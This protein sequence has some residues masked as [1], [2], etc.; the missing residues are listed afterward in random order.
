MTVTVV[1][2]YALAIAA[3]VLMLL[4]VVTLRR[5]VAASRRDGEP[6]PA[7]AILVFGGGVRPEGPS[8][9]VRTRVDHAARLYDAGLAPLVFCSGGCEGALSEA[10]VMRGL[11]IEH[12]V[13]ADAVIPDDHGLSTRLALESARRMGRGRWHRIIL[14]S[15]PHHLH[16]AELEACRQGLT[17]DTVAARR[18]GRSTWRH[19]VFDIRQHVREVLAVWGYALTALPGDRVNEWL[20]IR[21]ARQIGARLAY[22]FGGADAV[23]AASVAIG[24]AIK[25]RVADVLDTQSVHTPA[26]GLHWPAAGRVGHPFGMRHGR[27]HGGVDLRAA[28]G[29]PVRAA[30]DG[31]VLLADWIG[32]YG[33]V[34]VVHH[35]GG[36][37]TCYA[38]LGGFVVEERAPVVEGALLGFVGSTGRSSGPHL[39]FE[40]RVHGSP[41]DPLV[42][43]PDTVPY[44]PRRQGQHNAVWAESI[45]LRGH[46]PK[47]PRRVLND[48]EFQALARRLEAN[49][50]RY[51]YLFA[52]PYDGHGGVPAYAMS[53][54][55]RASVRRLRQLVPDVVLLPW[56]GGL[57]H[58]TV[59]LEDPQWVARAIEET[60]R[61]V[62]TLDVPGVHVDFE[63]IVPE[64]TY[65]RRERN[66]PATNEGL[67][68]YGARHVAFTRALRERLPQAFLSVVIPSTS[69]HVRPWKQKH[70][71]EEAAT[72]ATLVDQ[73]ALMHYD[74]SIADRAVFAASLDEQ[75]RHVADWRARSAS[76]RT[77]FLLAVGT[78]VNARPLRHHR[79]LDV[80][81]LEHYLPAI[82]AAIARTQRDVRLV[83]GL[84]VYCDWT[85]KDVD[86]RRFRRL[87]TAGAH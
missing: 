28:Q 61:L 23:A 9:T 48:G 42:Y 78:F 1:L 29:T 32:P 62:E 33:N 70:S 60:A 74:T 16:R 40:V 25:A 72:L 83:D 69:G 55:A 8:L 54:T 63:F 14:V 86:W 75:L 82:D 56:V 34:V 73:I 64:A 35:G 67:H 31:H 51:V 84:A 85:T 37:A 27:L 5:I 79:H 80:E 53:E 58:R 59:H 6:R 3:A 45:Y 2:A 36:L 38:H 11:L 43:L 57:Q 68:E 7:D 41:V 4:A 30:A 66:L 18:R 10:R 46:D 77:Q 49:D 24:A 13:P 17:V 44:E 65:V 52:G 12:G 47:K 20:P 21:V 22:L 71:V 76:A 39:H 50:I 15:S 81:G 19:V 26:S 87:W